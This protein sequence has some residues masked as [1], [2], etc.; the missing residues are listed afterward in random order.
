M[1]IFIKFNYN[2]ASHD[3]VDTKLMIQNIFLGKLVR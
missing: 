2:L 3:Q 1:K